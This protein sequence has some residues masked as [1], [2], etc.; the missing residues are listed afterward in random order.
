V[1]G[2]GL[3]GERTH[4]RHLQRMRPPHQCALK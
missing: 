4:L 1:D 2:R 3:T